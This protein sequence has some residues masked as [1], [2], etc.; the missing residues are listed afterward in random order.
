MGG[1]LVVVLGY[2]DGWSDGLHPI[3][4]ARLNAADPLLEGARTVVLSGWSRR[5][6]RP[7][8]SELMRGALHPGDAEVVCD[9]EARVTAETV[10]YV[11]ALAR[12][13][14]VQEVVAVTSWWHRPRTA[15][16]FRALL[17]DVPVA[18]KGVRT[19]WSLRLL[20]REL[21]A[22]PLVPVQLAIARSRLRRLAA[23]S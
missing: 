17:R 18:V 2:S 3:C 20:L 16:L 22:L 8:E 23:P 11:A 6:G 21:C 1:R 15:L 19:P 4:A 10:A 13:R 14:D 7:A 5:A 12:E 9:P